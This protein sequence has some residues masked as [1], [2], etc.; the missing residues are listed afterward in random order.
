ME[1]E[2]ATMIYLGNKSRAEGVGDCLK[3]QDSN[4][5]ARSRRKEA[6]SAKL[7]WKILE[8]VP[9]SPTAEIGLNQ[10]ILSS[11]SS[12]QSNLYPHR[13]GIQNLCVFSS[14]KP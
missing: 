8:E 1:G 10:E 9:G 6:L 2:E 7:K 5:S 12:I 13:R 14:S 4:N 11:S 3:R